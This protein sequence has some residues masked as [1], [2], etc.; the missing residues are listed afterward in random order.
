MKYLKE[1][2]ES[3]INEIFSRFESPMEPMAFE[4][5]LVAISRVKATGFASIANFFMRNPNIP[6][7]HVRK[8]IKLYEEWKDK[9][10][11]DL[12]IKTL[13]SS[14]PFKDYLLISCFQ[15]NPND[16][17]LPETIAESSD[18]SIHIVLNIYK[19]DDIKAK[20]ILDKIKPL[21]EYN[22]QLFERMINSRILAPLITKVF[23]KALNLFPLKSINKME[24]SPEIKFEDLLYS[25]SKTSSTEHKPIHI[26]FL[27]KVI[28][29]ELNIWH[30]R[31]VANMLKTYSYY[32]LL[33]ILNTIYN[34]QD[35]KVLLFIR[36]LEI[37]RGEHLINENGEFLSR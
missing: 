9:Y 8:I 16:P 37:I 29:S 19:E 18:Y 3:I 4:D 5:A 32:E 22:D 2:P 23:A 14:I 20:N 24:Q 28:A 27:N 11:I 10:K 36:E 30:Y 17:F 1:A 25:F 21:T 15:N 7:Y 13:H 26:K 33:D 6:A 34:T 35:D 31:Y 12:E